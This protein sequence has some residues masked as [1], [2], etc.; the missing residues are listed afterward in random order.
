MHNVRNRMAN[1]SR[2]GAPVHASDT[3]IP[4]TIGLPPAPGNAAP[5]MLQQSGP[6]FPDDVLIPH[7]RGANI[8]TAPATTEDG[9]S[10][11]VGAEPAPAK[12]K[13]T[14]T[15]PTPRKA[16]ARTTGKT[17]RKPPKKRT[18]TTAEAKAQAP[19]ARAK[20]K[21]TTPQPAASS[22]A[23]I[24]LAKVD[25]SPVAAT[26]APPVATAMTPLSERMAPLPRG[27]A[28]VAPSRGIVARMVNWLAGLAPRKKRAAL[29]R[30]RRSLRLPPA[31]NPAT[32]SGPATMAATPPDGD[33][34]IRRMML[35]LSE[36]NAR[37]RRELEALRL[38]ADK[39]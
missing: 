26:P 22:P 32:A 20:A 7:A 2:N 30:A 39:A 35:E 29:P 4:P 33:G 3:M 19:R 37:L 6:R 34:L 9:R 25:A 10:D 21:P 16:R 23:A 12:R 17:G 15:A 36:E 5:F 1:R 8:T 24:P 11:H 13:R 14:A 31:G 27:R 38:A 28:V 18:G